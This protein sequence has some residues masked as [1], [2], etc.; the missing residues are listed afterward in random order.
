MRSTS[1]YHRL[2]VNVTGNFKTMSGIDV[3]AKPT[4]KR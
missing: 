2:R 3:E 1:R 4:G